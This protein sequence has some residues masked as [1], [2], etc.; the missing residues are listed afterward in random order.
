MGCCQSQKSHLDQSKHDVKVIVG[1]NG[2]GSPD[3]RT[4]NDRQGNMGSSFINIQTQNPN[5][6]NSP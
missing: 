3:G 1:N 2:S 6:N 5:P 4:G